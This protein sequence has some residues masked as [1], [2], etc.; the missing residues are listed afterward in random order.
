MQNTI[1]IVQT[2]DLDY[3]GV[4]HF[5][6]HSVYSDKEKAEV[7]VEYLRTLTILEGVTDPRYS[8]VIVVPYTVH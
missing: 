8:S 7:A 1:Y 5:K 2:Q 3:F 4:R 6:V